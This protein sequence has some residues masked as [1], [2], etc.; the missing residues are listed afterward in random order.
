MKLHALR[1]ENAGIFAAFWCFSPLLL[2]GE[3]LYSDGLVMRAHSRTHTHTHTH[4]HTQ[5]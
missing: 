2:V 4:T 5:N 1:K 3:T